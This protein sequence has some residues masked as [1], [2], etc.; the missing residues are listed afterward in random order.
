[1]LISAGAVGNR[2]VPLSADEPAQ[3]RRE[4]TVRVFLPWAAHYKY[5][6]VTVSHATRGMGN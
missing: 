3:L 1:M 4:R 6:I 2:C 5:R